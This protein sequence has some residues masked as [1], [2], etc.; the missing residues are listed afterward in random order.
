MIE[1]I[2]T[3]IEKTSEQ[4]SFKKIIENANFHR[5]RSNDHLDLNGELN[6]FTMILQRTTYWTYNR[7]I[8][9]CSS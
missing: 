1:I 9:E 4:F 8:V 3:L 7:A 5:S 2:R 6:M